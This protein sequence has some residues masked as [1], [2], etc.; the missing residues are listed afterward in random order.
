MPG[1]SWRNGGPWR[2]GA[3][4]PNWLA[5]LSGCRVVARASRRGDV[6]VAEL[7]FLDERGALVARMEGHES[8]M[9]ASLAAAFRRNAVEA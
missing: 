5:G 4:S 8:T 3:R 1:P 9:D 7:E 6:A 2:R